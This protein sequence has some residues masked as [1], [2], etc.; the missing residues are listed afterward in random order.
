M[1]G[2]T[3]LQH[4]EDALGSVGVKLSEDETVSIKG[5]RTLGSDKL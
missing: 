4:L 2:T 3:K 1:D 5:H